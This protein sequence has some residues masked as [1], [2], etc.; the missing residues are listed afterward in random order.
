MCSK[1]L[2]FYYV[3]LENI[4]ELFYYFSHIDHKSCINRINSQ[5]S[6]FFAGFDKKNKK[7]DFDK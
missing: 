4:G 1:R 7:F 3:N 2:S 5:S 6:A